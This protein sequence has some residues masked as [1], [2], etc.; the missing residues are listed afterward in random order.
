[1]AA[2]RGE[3]RADYF[4]KIVIVG[5]YKC[6]KT[7]LLYR[8]TDKIFNRSLHSTVG[9]DFRCKTLTRDGKRIKLQIW[10]T[11]G[12]ERFRTAVASYY[13]GAT[14]VLLVYDI[15]SR[16]S[17][18]SVGHWYMQHNCEQEAKAVLVGNKC[19]L[20]CEREVSVAEGRGLAKELGLPFFET[21]AEKNIN[22]T[23]CFEAL[24]D[25][26]LEEIKQ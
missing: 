14:G 26:I 5:D 17:F 8:Y 13:R 20:D 16:Q 7:S 24:V 21:S 23:D 12:H 11:A 18:C 9:V 1:M 15:T 25:S 6:G 2:A 19:H 4:F 22:V 3:E 10:D